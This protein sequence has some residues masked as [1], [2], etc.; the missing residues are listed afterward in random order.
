MDKDKLDETVVL[1]IL[2]MKWYTTRRLMRA[3]HKIV[4]D[5]MERTSVLKK[6]VIRKE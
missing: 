4:A 2:G 3:T 6:Y 5:E 1:D